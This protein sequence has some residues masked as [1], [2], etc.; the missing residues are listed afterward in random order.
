MKSFSTAVVLLLMLTLVGCS[1]SAPSVSVAD[2]NKT[3]ILRLRNAYD[4]YMMEHGNRGPA[5]EEAFKKF[6]TTDKAAGVRLGR[7]G[8]DVS[9]IDDIFVSERDGQPFKVRYGLQGLADHAIVFEAEGL[10]G[11]RMVALAE[12]REMDQAE[13][14]DHFSGKIKPES[15]DDDKDLA[16][17]QGEAAAAGAGDNVNN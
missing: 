3:N 11:K 5:D 17:G 7:M 15:P 2:Y 14:D 9:K 6:L 1:P 8:V 16:E 13:Y 10:E 12:P 4:M